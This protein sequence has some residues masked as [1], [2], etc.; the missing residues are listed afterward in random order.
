MIALY[1]PAVFAGAAVSFLVADIVS[2]IKAWNVAPALAPRPRSLLPDTLAGLL[3]RVRELTEKRDPALWE[4]VCY[5]L[6]FHVRAGET[7]AQAVRGVAAEGNSFAH[8][9][10]K[11]VSQVYDSGASLEAAFG[12][13]SGRYGEL[14]QIASVM[15][16]GLTSGGNI[17]HLL[18]H[19]AEALRRKRLDRGELRS[20]MTEARA[21]AVLL[22]LLP[23]GIGAFTYS[24]DPLA[25]K[26]LWRDPVGRAL[27][28]AGGLLWIIG[29][30]AV[31]FMLR[32][33]LPKRHRRG[34]ER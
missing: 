30:I 7:P 34:E 11:T 28:V 26:A 20:K 13:V 27:L 32:S 16:M 31:A 21:T 33:L 5:A 12:S 15:E 24:Q 14:A 9:V 4:E 19:L 3:V 25:T 1:T 2:S 17:P 29:N 8:E 22:S 10:L 23:W 18:C 6:A